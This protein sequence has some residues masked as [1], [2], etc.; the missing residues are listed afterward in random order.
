[1]LRMST[2]RLPA[3]LLA[4]AL[5]APAALAQGGA[6]LAPAEHAPGGIHILTVLPDGSLGCDTATES[7]AEALR[8]ADRD[9]GEVRL[10]PL[11]SLNRAGVSPF[12]IIIRATDQLLARPTALLAFRRAAARW[13]RIIQNPV[14][15]VID[16][17]YGPNRF[18]SGPFPTNVIASANSAQQFASGTAG[19]AEI[20]A[21][22]IANQSDAPSLA[23]LNA[24]PVPTPST[25]SGEAG[26]TPLGRGI[27]G[28]ISLQ[29][30]GFRPAVLD[31]DPTVNPFG[32]IPNI[33]FN[34]AFNYDFNPN[35]GISP[36]Q[37][38][39]EAV[40]AHE[41]G[42]TLGF[43]STIGSATVA[44][45]IFTPWDLFRVRPDAVVPGESYTDGVGWE[46]TPRVITPGPVSSDGVQVM[47]TGDAEYETSTATGSR[48][49]GDGQQASHWRDDALR[50]PGPNRKIGIMD[51]TIGAGE[52]IEIS[53][54]DIRALDLFGYIV[55]A[56]PSTA[57]ATLTIGGQAIDIDF[58]TPTF[59]G[60]LP[61][62]GGSL[63]VVLANTGTATDLDFEFEVMIDSVQ[64]L[65]T[66]GPPSITL[67]P[68]SG[69]VAPGAQSALS[70]TLGGVPGGVVVY[71]RLFLRTNDRQR[72]FADI[73]FHISLG[74]PSLA[75]VGAPATVASPS[76][77]TTPATLAVTN[78]GDAPVRYVRVL[79]PAASEPG[80]A[81]QPF[82][83]EVIPATTPDEAA[84][85]ST[86][87]NE[88][89]SRTP[90]RLD[91]T[92]NAAIRLYDLA[93]V[94]TGEIAVVDGG[95][96]AT[97]T[98]YL[99]PA[100][101]SA[102]TGT[103]TSATSF[104]GEVTG[105]AYNERTAT[106]WLAVQQTGIVH[107]VRL[108]NAAIVSTGRTF[109]TGIEPF[110]MDYSPEIDAFLFTTFDAAG[111][112]AFDLNGRLLPGYPSVVDDRLTGS[113]S[114]PGLSFT[115]GLLDVSITAGRY[116]QV[117][118]FGKTFTNAGFGTI[119]TT[120]GLQRSRLDPNGVIYVSTRTSGTTASIRA[121]DPPDLPA[122]VGTRLEAATPLFSV[123]L[124]APGATDNLSLI[125][126]TR[127][128]PQGTLTD[129]LAFLTNAPTNRIVRFP[130]TINV[131]PVGAED[132]PLALD[133]VAT[134]PNPARDA[135]VVQLT[136]SSATDVTVGV[137]NTLGQR[138]ALLA[139]ATPLT[140]GTHTLDFPTADL[141]AGVYVVRVEA[142][143]SLSTH[144]VTVVR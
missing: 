38:D 124:L 21:A 109:T 58:L 18:N 83:G 114:T 72:A 131:L 125:V 37:T 22:L 80:T 73:P 141:A 84:E 32:T 8:A 127:G 70:L 50:P 130:V 40:T 25:I 2:L 23:L 116:V 115:E 68:P 121:F 1:M 94:P 16:L 106:Y 88:V 82:D 103:F 51:P 74:T 14:T 17:D 41:I 55:N 85:T 9:G 53:P 118:Q 99:V 105:I 90:G 27:G 28:L 138:V 69:S 11:P 79:E 78:N 86:V 129:E 97:T 26:T 98:V 120:Y 75:P 24:I 81:R 62:T 47:F 135:A 54:A 144:K 96:V 92:G 91:F 136:L 111:L 29:V 102:V 134:W 142:G 139:Q 128:T 101:L 30:L 76:G 42:H 71:G 7:Q 67:T 93:Q 61:V 64:T 6:R 56:T 100:D 5:L 110:G 140:A 63:P 45:P 112:Y 126:D 137:Y 133:A 20:R 44:S 119:P 66:G 108:E 13:E 3:G 60:S 59:R 15:T 113:T 43:T 107:E 117:G 104:G 89:V 95:T 132:G 65:S 77:E 57:V 31:P 10:T 34:S 46:V 12:T 87:G 33:G 35:D 122:N 36:G 48:T 123:D 52:Q 19:P 4:L 49:G 143:A 39:F